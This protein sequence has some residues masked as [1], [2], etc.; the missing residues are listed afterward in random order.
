M[1]NLAHVRIKK[2]DKDRLLKE[3][4]EIFLSENPHFKNVK[5][6]MPFLLNRIITFYIKS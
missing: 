1:H 6:T 2:D 4:K 5:I 3:C